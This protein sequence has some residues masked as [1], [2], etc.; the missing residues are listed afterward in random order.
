MSD[1]KFN[2]EEE[3]DD[4]EPEYIVPSFPCVIEEPEEEEITEQESE[5][6]ETQAEEGE[7]P[8]VAESFGAGT[9]IILAA[10]TVALAWLLQVSVFQ[11]FTV[12]SASMAP[13]IVAGD[14]VLVNKAAYEVVL[15]DSEKALFKFAF[16]RRGDIV[17]VAR[18]KNYAEARGGMVSEYL[19][20]RIAAIP[21]DSVK[22]LGADVL[23]NEGSVRRGAAG[24]NVGAVQSAV[25]LNSDEYF[26]LGDNFLNSED[27]RVFGPVKGGE[28]VGRVWG[29]ILP[30]D[31]V[32][33]HLK[34]FGKI[35]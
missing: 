33:N 8:E 28:I 18:A 14:V 21:G 17:L 7:A 30:L 1:E 3:T 4:D 16:P 22:V 5:E 27:S 35:K 20:K 32:A 19:V 10:V 26:L 29:I 2:D 25:K 31:I 15:P 34:R 12:P 9:W 6:T 13:T 11:V 23:V 24:K